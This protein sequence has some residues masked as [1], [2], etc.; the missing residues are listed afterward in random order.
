MAMDLVVE[1]YRASARFPREER[2]GLTAQLRRAAASIPAN[3]AEGNARS[4]RRDN[5]GFISVASGSLAETEAFVL[6][7]MRLGYL[8]IDEARPAMALLAQ[9][10]RMLRALRA[11]LLTPPSSPIPHPPSPP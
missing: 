4:T 6:L 7:A 5:A 8:P 1:V 10:G 2:F 11:R 9:I 3:I